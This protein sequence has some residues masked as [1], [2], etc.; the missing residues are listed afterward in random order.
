VFR[1]GILCC[2]LAAVLL[3][4][5]AGPSSAQSDA[6]IENALSIRS[7]A[8]GRAALGHDPVAK[9]SFIPIGVRR[10][11]AALLKIDLASAEAELAQAVS[12]QEPGVAVLSFDLAITMATRLTTAANGRKICLIPTRVETKAGGVRKLRRETTLALLDDGEWYFVGVR[13]SGIGGPLLFAYPDLA[14]IA[15]ILAAHRR[16]QDKAVQ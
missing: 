12:E 9:V 13:G 6:A 2:L 8:Y 7:A 5:A 15:G 11:F 3:I 10:R 14:E 4:A 16:A 1:S